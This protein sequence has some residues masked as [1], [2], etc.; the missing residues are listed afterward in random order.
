M[1]THSS[2]LSW[3]IPWTEEPGGPQSMRLQSVQH[4]WSNVACTGT[5]EMFSKPLSSFKAGFKCQLFWW[6]SLIAPLPVFFIHWILPL[7]E[8]WSSWLFTYLFKPWL[9]LLGCE[10][11]EILGLIS[12]QWIVTCDG[13]K[14]HYL[15][16]G[17]R[18]WDQDKSWDLTLNPRR[19]SQ[20]L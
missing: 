15:G 17:V 3:K 1:A 5:S 20:V 9:P 10:L 16:W 13:S 18:T 11:M 2:I 4:D 14:R 19:E 6:L 12:E 7:T 8:T